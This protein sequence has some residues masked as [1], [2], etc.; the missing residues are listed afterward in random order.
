MSIVKIINDA[1][2]QAV[3]DKNIERR[4]T[5]KLVKAYFTNLEKSGSI[6]TETDYMSGLQK[7]VKV[8]KENATQF[9]QMAITELVEAT[10]IE[11]FVPKQMTEEEVN[12]LI[13]TVLQETD[14]QLI[15]KNMGTI[16]KAVVTAS[17]GTTDGKTVSNLV[18]KLIK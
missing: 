13:Q 4:D 8:R 2:I 18:N 9:P 15:K 5:L 12:V 3:K 16:V 7:M 6:P 10:I 17:G 1:Y 14:L 11:E